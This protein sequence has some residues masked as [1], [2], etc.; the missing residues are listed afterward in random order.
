MLSLIK[1][2]LI[3]I[4]SDCFVIELGAHEL[5]LPIGQPDTK[6]GRLENRQ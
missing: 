6:S 1:K 2:Q 4:D 3:V 5:K